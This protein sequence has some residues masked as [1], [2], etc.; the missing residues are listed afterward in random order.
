MPTPFD[1]S[2]PWYNATNSKW[3][4]RWP[5]KDGLLPKITIIDPTWLY[6]MSNSRFS[7]SQNPFTTMPTPFDHFFL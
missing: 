3:H 5:P 4:P 1:H 6:A 7:G 2:F